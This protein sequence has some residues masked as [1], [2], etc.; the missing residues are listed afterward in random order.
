MTRVTFEI[1]VWCDKCGERLCSISRG[2]IGYILVGPCPT[3]LEEARAEGYAD[4]YAEG[5]AEGHSAGYDEGYDEGR[6]EGYAQGWDAAMN[7][8]EE[9]I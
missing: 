1:E 7:T 5:Q 4:G 6:A 9:G 2:D 3:C 8:I